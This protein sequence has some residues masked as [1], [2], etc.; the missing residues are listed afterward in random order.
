MRLGH[1]G[2]RFGDVNLRGKIVLPTAK[3]ETEGCVGDQTSSV[4]VLPFHSLHLCYT[5]LVCFL[6]IP[7]TRKVAA[8][9]FRQKLQTQAYFAV[10]H[11]QHRQHPW[12]SAS[13]STSRQRCRR[14]G[15]GLHYPW[16]ASCPNMDPSRARRT[17]LG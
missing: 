10:G 9:V 6:V 17:V 14:S 3:L 5:E 8:V 12:Q 11:T 1:A 2:A 4:K 16:A 7:K 15:W 13:E